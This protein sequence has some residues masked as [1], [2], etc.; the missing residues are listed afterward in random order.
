VSV[1]EVTHDV[2]QEQFSDYLDHSLPER[3][4]ERV[5]EHLATCRSC[6]ACLETLRATAEALGQLPRAAV[7]DRVRQ[8]L[9]ALADGDIER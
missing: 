9:I 8:R 2:I 4:H 7:P 6:R 3:A 5:D 1:A